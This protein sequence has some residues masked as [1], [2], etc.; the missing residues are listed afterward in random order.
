MLNSYP[1]ELS[2]GKVK[3]WMTRRN[4]A[5]VIHIF[6]S[7][8]DKRLRSTLAGEPL[9]RIAR[10]RC[11][12]LVVSLLLIGNMPQ[13]VAVSTARDVN[14]YKLYAHMKLK[15]AKQYRCLELLWNKESNWNP[16]ADN[17][18]ST[19]YGIP[20]LLKLKA[21]DPYIQMDLG[22]KYIKHRHLTP[23]KALAFHRMTG[24]Y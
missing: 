4:Y 15:D 11:I 12:A 10:R 21:K 18:K 14:N 19:A 3:V 13:S 22:L 9:R 2:T 20:Q 8:L 16:R 6:D 17:P 1:Q 23:C 24:H 7:V 5:Q